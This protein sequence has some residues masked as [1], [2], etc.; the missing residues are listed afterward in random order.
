MNQNIQ[1]QSAE[2][3]IMVFVFWDGEGVSHVEF[4]PPGKTINAI[5]YCDTLRRLRDAV[6]WKRYGHL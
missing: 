2:K 1:P 6:R 3:K 4:M 5:A